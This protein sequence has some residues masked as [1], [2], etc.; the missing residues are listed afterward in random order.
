MNHKQERTDVK[1]AL[2]PFKID[3]NKLTGL[4]NFTTICKD[5]LAIPAYAMLTPAEQEPQQKA[6][7]PGTA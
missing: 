6:G 4:K 3:N 1:S 2:K 7:A 5:P